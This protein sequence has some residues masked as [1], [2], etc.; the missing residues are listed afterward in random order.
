[1]AGRSKNRCITF[2]RHLVCRADVG[3]SFERLLNG[4]WSDFWVIFCFVLRLTS[5]S[6]FYFGPSH[7]N[8]RPFC[9]RSSSLECLF[10]NESRH[11]IMPDSQY[12]VLS[13]EL[14][15]CQIEH[16]NCI[17]QSNSML[18][19]Y[20]TFPPC[21]RMLIIPR[22]HD[23]SE[24]VFLLIHSRHIANGLVFHRKHAHQEQ[25]RLSSK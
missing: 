21:G 9:C 24:A 14:A 13:F 8:T 6:I 16:P 5:F 10:S 2:G 18:M 7:T 12:T 15:E 4:R 1:M 17:H 25:T 19:Q 3:I 11:R 23:D 20:R 22:V